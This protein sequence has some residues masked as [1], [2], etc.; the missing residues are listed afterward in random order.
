[1]MPETTTFSRALDVYWGTALAGR[2]M[3]N[4]AGSLS[5]AYDPLFLQSAPSGISIS[6]PL[7]E[8]IFEGDVVKAFFSGLLPEE[9]VRIRLAKYLGVSDKNAFALLKAVGGECAGALSLY[10]TGEQ[11][12]SVNTDDI[13]IL[14]DAR[15]AEILEL[16][17][18]RPFLAGEGLRLSLAGAQDKLAVGF[19]KGHVL[20]MKG[21]QP[22]THILK[23]IID[24]I[25]DS[26]HNELFCMRLAKMVGLD[27]P[28][29]DIHFV[30][31]T[32]Y[33]IVERYDRVRQMDGNV[34][35]IH[36]EDF[37]Q[38][39]GVLPELKYEREGGPSISRCQ[40]IILDHAARPAADQIKLLNI[41]IFNYLI[42]NA[43][44]HGKNFS[45]LYRGS[46]PEL[47]P[48]YDLLSTAIYP[49]LSPKMAMKV[50][51]KYQPDDV[52]LGH[53]HRLV[54]ETKA[55]QSALNKQ[56]K[57]MAISTVENALLLKETLEAQGLSSPV[58]EKICALIRVNAERIQK[59]LMSFGL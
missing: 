28:F 4:S 21:G 50:G 56:L 9:N 16:I 30:N 43:D 29:A 53:W 15:L 44:A 24:R 35:R 51:G 38:A 41:V 22:T 39:L 18:R 33:Y 3:Q 49:D 2:L 23:P 59:N 7:Q 27:V 31:D 42:G 54:P 36:Q 14:D 32:P 48:A 13:E 57:A 5:F 19:E 11:P 45:L 46:K 40:Q 25:T 55:S 58:F 26:A 17:K 10:P 12:V 8:S 52:L 34:T 20:L 1:M 6:M 37:C 47:A